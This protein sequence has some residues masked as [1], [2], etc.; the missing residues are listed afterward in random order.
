MF[1]RVDSDKTWGNGFILRQEVQVRYYEEVFTQSGDTLEQVAQGS[2]GFPI[3]GG[4]QGQ[5]GCSS[6]Q[7]GLVVGNPAHSMGVGT[8]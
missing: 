7:P 5:A 1:M 6:G 8:R 3:T 4:L 2:C